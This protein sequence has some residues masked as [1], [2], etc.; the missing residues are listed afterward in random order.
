MESEANGTEGVGVESKDAGCAET[1]ECS[2][3]RD[4][5]DEVR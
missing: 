2:T 1:V 5:V 4:C 3:V